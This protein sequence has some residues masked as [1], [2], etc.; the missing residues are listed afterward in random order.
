MSKH[1]YFVYIRA[2]VLLSVKDAKTQMKSTE[3]NRCGNLPEQPSQRC[4][5]ERG[6]KINKKGNLNILKS[7][8]HCFSFKK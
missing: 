7:I 1:Y 5:K 4:S 6:T 3:R 8:T 2:I